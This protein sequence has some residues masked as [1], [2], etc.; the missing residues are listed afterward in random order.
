MSYLSEENQTNSG[1]HQIR[2]ER[3]AYLW[4][5]VIAICSEIN[6]CRY[7]PF[8]YTQH[9][10]SPTL[11]CHHM[12]E[13]FAPSSAIYGFNNTPLPFGIKA[14]YYLI[15]LL[16]KYLSIATLLPNH[17][18][19]KYFDIMNKWCRLQK[20]YYGGQSVLRNNGASNQLYFVDRI[21][22][23]GLPVTGFIFVPEKSRRK[24]RQGRINNKNV[25]DTF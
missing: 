1:I 22:F 6:S 11:S 3:M 19:S 2:H 24:T 8:S 14:V 5:I 13:R 21:L 16:A 9:R 7:T 15:H 18:L 10:T 20:F 17:M 23:K 4:P 12:I 25:N